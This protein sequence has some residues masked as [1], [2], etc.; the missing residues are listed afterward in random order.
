MLRISY[1]G[2]N[3]VQ[4]M[5]THMHFNKKHNQSVSWTKKLYHDHDVFCNSS[6]STLL[7]TL[8]YMS[9]RLT[10]LHLFW[11]LF[12]PASA[13]G[14]IKSVLSVFP[15]V[16]WLVLS[17]IKASRNSPDTLD[18]S[19]EVENVWRRTPRLGLHPGLAP[20]ISME[21]TGRARLKS[22]G[23]IWGAPI[24]HCQHHGLI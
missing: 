23:S 4:V 20:G 10:A 18:M 24:L 17:R 19:G 12:P 7:M 5:T 8:V 13:V 2:L 14:G 15:S 1:K 6:Y 22:P 3:H 16:S 11:C 21:P 9:K